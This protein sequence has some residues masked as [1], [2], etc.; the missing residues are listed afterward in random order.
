MTECDT[1]PPATL[2]ALYV[3]G[4]AD[5]EWWAEVDLREEIRKTTG[6]DITA[7]T[8]HRTVRKLSEVGRIR[9]RVTR[10]DGTTRTEYSLHNANSGGVDRADSP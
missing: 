2:L 1:A 7:S 6:Y 10:T 9:K 5:Q 3:L 8:M 4:E